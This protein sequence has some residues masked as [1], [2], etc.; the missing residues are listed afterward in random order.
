MEV[1]SGERICQIVWRP[2][3]DEKNWQPV[4]RVMDE[5]GRYRKRERERVC[6]LL[7]GESVPRS[8]GWVNHSLCTATEVEVKCKVLKCYSVRRVCQWQE[9][10][11]PKMWGTESEMRRSLGKIEWGSHFSCSY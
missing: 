5:T 3:I 2:E 8:G 6:A 10:R 1:M 7:C 9:V 4:N 11:D